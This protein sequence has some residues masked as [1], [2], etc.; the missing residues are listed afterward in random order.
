MG[1]VENSNMLIFMWLLT[2]PLTLLNWPRTCLRML[3]GASYRR[4]S[5]HGRL[6][7]FCRMLFRAFLL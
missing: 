1:L 5:R 7:H 6:V 2:V 3:L 4:V